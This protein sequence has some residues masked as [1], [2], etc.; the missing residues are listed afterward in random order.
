MPSTHDSWQWRPCDLQDHAL[1]R[2]RCLVLLPLSKHCVVSKCFQHQTWKLDLPRSMPESREMMLNDRKNIFIFSNGQIRKWKVM[3][4]P[5]SNQNH[6]AQRNWR[7][8][9]RGSGGSCNSVACSHSS[10][11]CFFLD[12]CLQ[13]MTKRPDWRP[14]LSKHPHLANVDSVYA[15]VTIYHI[16]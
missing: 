4:L 13:G 10:A 16:I 9:L 1:Q 8:P 15:H 7:L 14:H 6:R 12:C 11:L 3:K 5:P 2:P